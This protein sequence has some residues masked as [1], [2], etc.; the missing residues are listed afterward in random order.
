MIDIN[1]LGTTRPTLLAN[2]ILWWVVDVPDCNVT[3]GKT[4]FEYQAP[5]PLYGAGESRY[6][7]LAYEQPQYDIDWHE[8]PMIP[9]V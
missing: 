5:L 7:I 8:E 1:P 2:G 3:A 9:E 6:V 4:L